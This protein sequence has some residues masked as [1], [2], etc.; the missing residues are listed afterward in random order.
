MKGFLVLEN[1]LN[2]VNKS[3]TS[4]GIL[5]KNLKKFRVLSAYQ[6]QM[7]HVAKTL[8]YKLLFYRVPKVRKQYT[9]L[10]LCRTN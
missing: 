9:Q 8:D 1:T 6:Q 3:P 5:G 2:T 7:K 10:T 4:Q